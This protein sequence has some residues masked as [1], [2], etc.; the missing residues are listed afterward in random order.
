M[1]YLFKFKTILELKRYSN[2]T[3]Q[4]YLFYLKLFQSFYNY[5]DKHL[6]NLEDRDILNSVVKIIKTKNYS[7]S[8]QKQ[9]IGSLSLFYKELLK[10][11]INFSIIYPTQKTDNLPSVFSKNEVKNLINSIEN[12]K[13]KAII[14][15]IYGL[16]LRISELISLELKNIDSDRMLVYINDSKGKKDRIVMLPQKLLKLLRS[17]FIKYK[18]KKY[19]FEGQKGKKYSVSSVRKVFLNAKSKAKIKKPGTVHTLRHSF[20]THLL[21]NGTDIRLIQKLLGHKN[22]KTTLIYTH[23]SKSSIQ[24]IES[25]LDSL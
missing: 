2:N 23:V 16:G 12:T 7:T 11:N 24:N 3:I 15:T 5:S 10:R 14:S 4:S 25:P 17:Y 19:L 8:S 9:L 6:D 21:E 22:I 13:H 20:A 1:S 18:P